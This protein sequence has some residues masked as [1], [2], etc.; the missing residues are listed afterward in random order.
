MPEWPDRHVVRG[1][2]AAGL[3]GRRIVAVRIGDPVVLRATRPVDS[4]GPPLA[5]Q[6]VANA[7]SAARVVR[8]PLSGRP[9]R[10]VSQ[11]STSAAG[12]GRAM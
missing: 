5:R 3:V 4:S 12:I 11:R 2:I 9:P 1:R 7:V 10:A 8:Q 6:L